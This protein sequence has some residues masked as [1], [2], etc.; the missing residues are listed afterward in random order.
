MYKIKK[1]LWGVLAGILL[2]GDTTAMWAAQTG[3]AAMDAI[4]DAIAD[5]NPGDVTDIVSPGEGITDLPGTAGDTDTAADR[6]KEPNDDIS[7]ANT[8]K[9]GK[10]ITGSTR[11]DGEV[12]IFKFTLKK[13]AY[14]NI[15]MEYIST[16]VGGNLWFAYIRNSKGKVMNKTTDNLFAD[17]NST[18]AESKQVKL[19]KG[20]YYVTVV[21]YALAYGRNYTLCVNKIQPLKPEL[22][23][24]KAENYDEVE[25]S[26][27][28]VPGAYG[29]AVYRST[30]KKGNYKK[31]C[32]RK[33]AL[34]TSWTD[35]SVLTGKTYY[36]KIKSIVKT[37]KKSIS[38]A[39]K[40]GSAT[41][42]PAAPY[43]IPEAGADRIDLHWFSVEGA[44]GYEVYRS[45]G[46]N[47]TYKK[48]KTIKKGTSTDF[49]DTK[50]KK[51]TTY[52]YKVRTYCKVKGKKVYSS[53]STVV[54]TAAE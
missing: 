53:Y 44:D 35:N 13:A 36:Y 32:T 54:Y 29:Y 5:V 3:N 16:N 27:K 34:S 41:P 42:L 1:I 38:S 19:K 47:G 7:S 15:S 43:V 28:P 46:Q 25:I 45:T 49:T 30:A 10:P 48:V 23:G 14:V 2:I 51:G 26:W 12:D 4:I 17:D 52:Y 40:I 50:V 8:I 18:Y 20:T 9:V 24:V 37:S 31:V 33:G 22:T 21:G 6:E 11:A 39:S